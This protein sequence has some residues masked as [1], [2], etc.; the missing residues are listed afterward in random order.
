MPASKAFGSACMGS[1]GDTEIMDFS[2]AFDLVR[3]RRRN[4]K[5]RIASRNR[6]AIKPPRMAPTIVPVDMRELDKR[7]TEEGEDV[8]EELG[9]AASVFSA[10]PVPLGM[11]A[12]DEASGNCA[13]SKTSI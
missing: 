12:L 5:A 11:N 9:A 8:G 3:L 13:A 6:K 2:M 7:E 4:K 1:I 10:A